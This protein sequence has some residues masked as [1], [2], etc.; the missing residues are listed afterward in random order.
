MRHLH[1]ILALLCLAISPNANAGETGRIETILA[2]TLNQ[3]IL[4]GY[5]RLEKSASNSEDAVKVL[6]NSSSSA[7]LAAAQTAFSQTARAWAGMEWFRV[8]PVIAENRVELMLFYP[9]RKGIGLRQVQAALASRDSSTTNVNGLKKKSVAMQGLG[10]LEFLLFGTGYESLAEAGDS[11]RCAYAQAVAENL[12]SISRSLH[13][14]WRGDSKV[15]RQWLQPSETNPLFAD[16]KGAISR[17]IGEMIH[18]LEAVKDVRIGAFLREKP[19]RDRPKSALFWRSANTMPMIAENLTGLK[20]LFDASGIEGVLP[21][22]F[23]SLGDTVRFE[24]DQAIKTAQSFEEPVKLVLKEP[25]TRKRLAYLKLATGYIIARLD[26]EFLAA[27][28]LNIG[29]SFGDGD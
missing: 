7:N 8:G 13:E 10:A 5:E 2:A 17:L 19:R 14:G 1:F 9:D 22:E 15:S 20:R 29:F 3:Y 21:K 16:E 28:G 6:C 4:P 24:F 12:H 27:T 26:G 25:K 11:Y 23:A 18:G